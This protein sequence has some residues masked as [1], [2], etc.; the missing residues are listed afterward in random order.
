M[1]REYASRWEATC[2]HVAACVGGCGWV[3]VYSHECSPLT[4]TIFYFHVLLRDVRNSFFF[5]LF[6]FPPSDARSLSSSCLWRHAAQ[7]YVALIFAVLVV[8]SFSV[9]FFFFFELRRFVWFTFQ[10][11]FRWISL[12]PL[13][14]FFFSLGCGCFC[15]RVYVFFCFCLCSPSLPTPAF[16]FFACIAFCGLCVMMEP[17]SA[18][19]RRSLLRFS[20]VCFEFLSFFASSRFV[21][22]LFFSLFS[23]LVVLTDARFRVSPYARW[24][25]CVFVFLFKDRGFLSLLPTHCTSVSYDP[26]K[27]P[28]LILLECSCVHFCVS[29]SF[30]VCLFHFYLAF[31]LYLYVAFDVY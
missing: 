9:R 2:T 3:G 27:A 22:S 6:C 19:S 7:M 4:R 12:F 29:L 31:S 24:Q 28:Y 5:C 15:V 23:E 18:A 14:P 30:F 17:K 11:P 1:K 16:F 21:E 26:R 8:F 20:F 10:L 25:P 13:F